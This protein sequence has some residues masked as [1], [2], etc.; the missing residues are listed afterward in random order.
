MLKKIYFEDI[1]GNQA[2][3]YHRSSSDKLEQLIKT[4]FK[5]GSGNMYGSAFYSTYNL[6]SLNGA[7]QS[8]GGEF[9]CSDNPTKFTI[10]DV[11]RVSKVIGEIYV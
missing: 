10:D 3:V 6:T 5:P 11:N 8:V 2:M 4:Q 1:Y 9:Y 7:P